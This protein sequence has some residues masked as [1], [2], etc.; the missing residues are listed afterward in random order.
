MV[1][2]TH[3][4]ILTKVYK[5]VAERKHNKQR[6]CLHKASHHIAHQLAERAVVIGDLSQR[7]IKKKKKE[8]ETKQERNKR[9][10]RNRLVYNDWGHYGFVQMLIYKCLHFGKNSI[11]STNAIRPGCVM[12]VS[13]S[14]TCPSRSGRMDARMSTAVW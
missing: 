2:C 3:L 11:S 6:D 8:H 5:R 10:I 9:R 12:P 14:R 1:Y 13:T 7:R 4:C